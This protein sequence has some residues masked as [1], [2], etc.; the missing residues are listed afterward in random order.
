VKSNAN[1]AAAPP[2][3][4]RSARDKLDDL[5]A[6][7]GDPLRDITALERVTFVMMGGKRIK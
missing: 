6:L 2:E 3:I 4:P 1:A 5:I 7:D